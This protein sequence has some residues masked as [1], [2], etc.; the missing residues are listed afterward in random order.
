MLD[1]PLVLSLIEDGKRQMTAAGIT[2]WTQDYPNRDVIQADIQQK[3]LWLFGEHASACAAVHLERGSIYLQR[4]VVS[5]RY[6]GQGLGSLMLDE[7]ITEESA[8]QRGNQLAVVTNHS[9]HKMQRL[10]QFKDFQVKRKFKMKDR[11]QYGDFIEFIRK[12]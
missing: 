7:V 11:E 1:L 12:I 10:L 9:N 3:E 8:L 2:Q 5:S 6:Q 4:F